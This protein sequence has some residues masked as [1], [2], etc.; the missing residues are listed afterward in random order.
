MV[1]HVLLPLPVLVKQDGLAQTAEQ[2]HIRNNNYSKSISIIPIIYS[3][4]EHRNVAT[5]MIYV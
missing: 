5:Y 3:E 4:Y 2:V 1:E